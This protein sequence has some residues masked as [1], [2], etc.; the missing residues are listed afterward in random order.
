MALQSI[1]ADVQSLENV[2]QQAN[3]AMDQGDYIT[4]YN[5]VS[6]GQ[7]KANGLIDELNQAIS[8]G[9]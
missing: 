6:N 3:N 7:N 4:A 2:P 8:R 9:Y 5:Q 1:Q